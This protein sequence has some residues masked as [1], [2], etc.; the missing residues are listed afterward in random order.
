MSWSACREELPTSEE[1][2][3]QI[4]HRRPGSLSSKWRNVFDHITPDRYVYPNGVRPST[5][6]ALMRCRPQAAL[7]LSWLARSCQGPAHMSFAKAVHSRQQLPVHRQLVGVLP[8]VTAKLR[9]PAPDAYTRSRWAPAT[10]TWC[11]AWT[12]RCARTG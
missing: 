3:L 10:V 12:A 9:L 1:A 11:W 4:I 5:I 2:P 8:T 6:P 7:A